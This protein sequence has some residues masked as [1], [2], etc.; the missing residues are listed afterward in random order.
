MA[1]ILFKAVKRSRTIARFSWKIDDS[2]DYKL[3]YEW[4]PNISH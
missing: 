3:C 1:A 4:C 2:P